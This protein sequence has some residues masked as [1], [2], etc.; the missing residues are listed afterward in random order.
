MVAKVEVTPEEKIARKL[1]GWLQEAMGDM[2]EAVAGSGDKKWD[3]KIRKAKKAGV[4]DV[5]GWLADELYNDPDTL[6]DMLGDKL[7]DE[8]GKDDALRN[9]VIDRLI[10]TG[11][12]ALILACNALRVE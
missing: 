6:Q 11:H 1:Q 7:C 3:A 12:S 5:Q 8:C 9:K 4:S 2:A 10:K